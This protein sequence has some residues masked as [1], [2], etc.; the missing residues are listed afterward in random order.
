MAKRVWWCDT[1]KGICLEK[2]WKCPVCGKEICDNCFDRFAV[3]RECAAGK[4]DDEV[5]TLSNWD[6]E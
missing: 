3:C 6:Y 5:K 2:P 4:T 1:C